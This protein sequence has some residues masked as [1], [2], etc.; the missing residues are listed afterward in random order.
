M[1]KA[2]SMDFREYMEWIAAAIGAAIAAILRLV[3]KRFSLRPMLEELM[4]EV[5]ELR[6]EVNE[7]R[8]KTNEN[9]VRLEERKHEAH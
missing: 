5:C 7:L 9:S 2:R 8:M 6:K 4:R 1:T 3:Y